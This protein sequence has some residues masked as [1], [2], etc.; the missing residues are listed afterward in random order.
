MWTVYTLA[1]HEFKYISILHNVFMQLQ[2]CSSLVDRWQ[3]DDGFES[4]S[5]KDVRLSLR[6]T[7][8]NMQLS[9]LQEYMFSILL[10]QMHSLLCQTKRSETLNTNVG[11]NV[12]NLKL[13]VNA[14]PMIC[15]NEVTFFK[16][17]KPINKRPQSEVGGC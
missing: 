10:G 16:V 4:L 2:K 13:N 3:E 11:Y 12:C 6:M 8:S 17:I 9:S 15:S 5:T 1:M 7:T 14:S